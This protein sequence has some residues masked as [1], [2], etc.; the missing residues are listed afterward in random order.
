MFYDVA[1]GPDERPLVV[2]EDLTTAPRVAAA[3][4]PQALDVASLGADVPGAHGRAL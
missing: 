4:V 2:R 1:G 3:H